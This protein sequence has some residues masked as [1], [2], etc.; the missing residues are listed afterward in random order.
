MAL[1][2]PPP[3]NKSAQ[4]SN[5]PGAQKILDPQKIK[6]DIQKALADPAISKDLVN[7]AEDVL[8][9]KRLKVAS[10]TQNGKNLVRL[11]AKAMAYWR[12]YEREKNIHMNRLRD[13]MM[14]E[15]HDRKEIMEE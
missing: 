5:R 4:K 15:V 11:N 13:Q 8:E 12:D 6:A 10:M 2:N 9:K 1:F 7:L 14:K 3:E